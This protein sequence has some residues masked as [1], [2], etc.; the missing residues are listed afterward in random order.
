L[1]ALGAGRQLA[2][3]MTF[4]ASTILGIVDVI[5]LSMTMRLAADDMIR[6]GLIQMDGK[7]FD[8]EYNVSR[9]DK[10]I[11]QAAARGAKVVCTPEVAVQ[12][13]PRAQLPQGNRWKSRSASGGRA[14][15]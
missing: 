6:V 15:R 1:V 9:A 2:R 8:K 12:G 5:V 10:G 4:R 13:Y 7:T 14:T 11:R 3:R